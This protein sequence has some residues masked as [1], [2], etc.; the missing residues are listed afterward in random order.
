MQK[1][2]LAIIAIVIVVGLVAYFT[3]SSSTVVTTTSTKTAQN[4]TP[5]PAAIPTTN[6]LTLAE[7]VSGSTAVV[8]HAT[9]TQLAYI[10]IYGKGAGGIAQLGSSVVLGP[11]EYTNVR[12][13][14]SPAVKAKD[15]IVAV[16]HADNGNG[17]FNAD[18]DL[19]ILENNAHITAVDVID[20]PSAAGDGLLV[21]PVEAFLKA[22]IDK[23][24]MNAA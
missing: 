3:R 14:L 23:T 4:T 17:T 12:I 9:L 16:L 20:V 21:A 13:P 11:G 6:T 24:M 1:V 18:E 5:Q 15:V 8:A 2:I 7:N 22:Q 19:S 10:V